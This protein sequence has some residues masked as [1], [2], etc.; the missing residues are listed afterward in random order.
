MAKW[1]DYL[2]IDILEHAYVACLET[3]RTLA[4]LLFS[5]RSSVSVISLIL[6]DGV[7]RSVD[8]IPN[9]TTKTQ[10]HH[11]NSLKRRQMNKPRPR[12]PASSTSRQIERENL[13]ITFKRTQTSDPTRSTSG[14]YPPQSHASK[15]QNTRLVQGARIS[16]NRGHDGVKI[17]TDGWGRRRSFKI[18]LSSA[19]SVTGV[20][21]VF[22]LVEGV[23]VLEV[24][25]F[26][27]WRCG[28]VDL[29]WR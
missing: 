27:V 13:S 9:T 16:T 29:K 26:G 15:P 12:V 3:F 11:W 28:G 14:A 21:V 5:S 7:L 6:S 17:S 24:R 4:S 19:S 25:V 10:N 2:D 18:G 8:C 22:A 23:D 20:L 1:I